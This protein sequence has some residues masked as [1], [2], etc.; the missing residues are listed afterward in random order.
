MPRT[1]CVLACV[2]LVGCTHTEEITEPSQVASDQADVRRVAANYRTLRVMTKE[3]VLVDAGLAMYCRGAT[4]GE[5]EAARKVS[6]PHAHT[7]VN[8]FMNDVA[9]GTFGKPNATYPVGS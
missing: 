7:W 3:P 4:Q 8:V 9:A 6:G 2:W 5:V 1:L